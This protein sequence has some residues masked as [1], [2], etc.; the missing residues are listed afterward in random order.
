MMKERDEIRLTDFPP[1]QGEVRKSGPS[2]LAQVLHHLPRD[3]KTPGSAGGPVGARRCR[4][5]PNR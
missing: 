1:K 4:R 2:D 3:Q 5:N